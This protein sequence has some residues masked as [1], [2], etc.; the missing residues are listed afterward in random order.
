MLRHKARGGLSPVGSF[1]LCAGWAAPA[2]QWGRGGDAGAQRGWCA[3]MYR[4]DG[5]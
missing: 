4:G 5:C 3:L 1:C 2:Q